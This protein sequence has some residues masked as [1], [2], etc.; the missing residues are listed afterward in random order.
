MSKQEIRR[1]IFIAL[2]AITVCVIVQNFYIFTKLVSILLGALKPLMIGFFIA[3]IF[4]IVM[5]F[6]EKHYLPKS[7]KPLI[8]KTRRPTCLVLSFTIAIAA[9]ILI[10]CIVVPEI[11]KAFG[12]LYDEIPPAF[13]KSKDF[14]IGKLNEYPDIQEKIENLEF[15]WA[16]IAGKLSKVLTSGVAG[17]LSSAWGIIGGVASTLTNIVL[18][19][20]FAIY[21]L[22]R[23]DKLICDINRLRRLWFSESFN[24]KSSHFIHTAN[25]TFK[26]FFVGQFIEAIIL[27]T[28]CF[29]GMKL[30]KLPYAAMSGTLVGVT[31]FIPIVGAFIGAGVSAFIILTENP[32]QALI[33]L[34]FLV[35]LQQ[36]EGNIIYPKVV[37]GT[38]G[39]PSIWTLAAV[40]IGGGLF[41]ILGM[42]L[43]VPLAGTLYK[44]SFEKLESAE[45]ERG[46]APTDEKPV[47]KTKQK[48][49]KVSRK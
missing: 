2:L 24:N 18:G 47:K 40:T 4:N 1:Y 21:M 20:I 12:V 29:I 25:D 39:L 8:V 41:G 14:V 27:G 48:P 11:I 13:T 5:N 9:I 19:I 16:S 22:L 33:F 23:K 28:L 42:L 32:M 6:F 45:A 17:I 7:Q 36:L 31:A 3:Y 37:G 10:M 49:K 38:V 44:L 43:G 15:D 26:S 30:L 46:I 34:I 35:I